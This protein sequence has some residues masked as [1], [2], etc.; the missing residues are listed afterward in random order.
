[1][2]FEKSPVNR[3]VLLKIGAVTPLAVAGVSAASMGLALADGAP[4]P[5]GGDTAVVDRDLARTDTVET[6]G[7]SEKNPELDGTAA[8]QV[9]GYITMAAAT[10]PKDTDAPDVVE[11][12]GQ[13]INTGDWG[14]WISAELMT[15]ID[16][17]ATDAVWLGPSSAVNVRAFRDGHD[18][19]DQLT[20]CLLYTSD[21]ADE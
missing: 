15:D 16:E 21:A 2:S 7:R 20:A 11:F 13:D 3:R 18:V 10:W 4:A 12:Q 9:A 1:M 5:S 17:H 8:K 14:D 19:S 6:Q